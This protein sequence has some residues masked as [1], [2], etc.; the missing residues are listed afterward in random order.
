MIKGCIF[1]L[2]GTI[3]DSLEDLCEATN[4]A[5]SLNGLPA[6]PLENYN[7]YV[8]DGVRKLVER[9]L[10][11]H[12]ELLEPCLKEFYD[13]YS[14]H[15]FDKTKTYP[16]IKTLIQELNNEN[17]QL[18]VVTNKPHMIAKKIVTA[19]FPQCFVSVYGNQPLYPTKP[20]P[21]STLLALQDMGIEKEECV[22]IGDSN[23]DIRTGC[24][25]HMKTIG[26]LWGFRD[27][28]ELQ[29]AGA[30]A[31]AHEAKEIRR[32]IDDWNK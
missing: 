31:I 4:Y 32:I 1:D 27:E 3:V 11:D 30:S 25:A 8:G 29:E 5:L 2:D 7:H 6:K 18:S 21:R 24:N 10:E 17:Y 28:K 20:D 13:Y 26:C 22:F 19:L 9:A 12:Q 14:K 15:C 16:G 23:V